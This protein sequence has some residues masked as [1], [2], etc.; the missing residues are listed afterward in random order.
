M[1]KAFDRVSHNFMR[2]VIRKMNFGPAFRQWIEILYKNPQSKILVNGFLTQSI[3]I[4]RSV[5]QGCPL[6]SMLFTLCQEP[7]AQRIR[8]DHRI[9]GTKIPNF[10]KPCKNIQF[11][12]DA[13]HPISNK[14]VPFLFENYKNFG[15]AS[16]S[17]VNEMK[18]EILLLGGFSNLNIHQHYRKYIVKKAELLGII[19]GKEGGKKEEFWSKIISKINTDILNWEKRDLS[20]KGKVLVINTILLAKVWYGAR[21]L[22]IPNTTI[23]K[24]NRQIFRFLWSNK[25]ELIKRNYLIRECKG[26]IGLIDLKSKCEALRIEKIKYLININNKCNITQ[27]WVGYGI[28]KVGLTLRQLNNEIA[29]NT[30]VHSAPKKSGIWHEIMKI[31]DATKIPMQQEF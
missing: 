23:K 13:T 1:E 5:R 8:K 9:Q 14:A 7:L 10:N 28:Y 4:G 20:F 27:P 6:S 2:K 16:G 24:I 30:Y 15:K 31:C 19:W 18:T 26:G 25:V 22:G 29:K 3:R 11:A 21:V 17:Q 12:D